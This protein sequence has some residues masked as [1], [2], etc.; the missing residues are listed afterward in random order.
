MSSMTQPPE[1]GRRQGAGD[2]EPDGRV[3]GR[4]EHLLGEDV[5]G[6]GQPAGVEGLEPAV[7]QVPDVG[8]AA[9]PVVLDR[10]SRKVVGFY[11]P[12]TPALGGAYA[13]QHSTGDL[14]KLGRSAEKP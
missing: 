10:F 7:D 11:G 12:G 5:A 14:Q 6:L 4:S 9:R 3:V 2:R 13:N 1:S 8:A